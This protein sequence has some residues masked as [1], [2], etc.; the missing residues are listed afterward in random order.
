MGGITRVSVQSV[1]YAAMPI[2]FDCDVYRMRVSCNGGVIALPSLVQTAVSIA[3]VFRASI[4]MS[5]AF[6]SRTLAAM[7]IAFECRVL[8]SILSAIDRARVRRIASA[9]LHVQHLDCESW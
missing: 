9:L 5:I 8:A 2:A 1:H 7:S 3:C 6:G 4:A